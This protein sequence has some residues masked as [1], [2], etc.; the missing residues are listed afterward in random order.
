MLLLSLLVEAVREFHWFCWIRLA[1]I[2]F[3]LIQITMC[4]DYG[5]I[6]SCQAESEYHMQ[7][8]N[9]DVHVLKLEASVPEAVYLGQR[10]DG[11]QPEANE[12]YRVRK[13]WRSL[14]SARFETVLVKITNSDG[15]VGWGEALAPVGPGILAETIRSLI[16]PQLIGRDPRF[17]RPLWSELRGLMR[18]RGH[19]VGHQADALAAVDIALWDLVGHIHGLSVS[20]MIGGAFHQEVPVYISGLPVPTNNERAKLAKDWF[21]K[22]AG[23]VKLHVGFGVQEDLAIFDAVAAAAPG[24]GIA[25]DAHWVYSR[26]DA[27]KLGRELDERGALFLEAPLAPEDVAGHVALQSHLST[28]VAVGE[29]LRNRYEFSQWVNAGAL[30]IL[31]PDIG[32]TG[33]TE[34]M[35]ISDLATTNHLLVAPHHSVGLGISFA[36]GMH[37]AAASESLLLFEYQP[38]TLEMASKILT[39]PMT[40]PPDLVPLPSGPGLGITVDEDFVNAYSIHAS[41]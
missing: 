13:P 10:P 24:L 4:I 29:T 14:Y 34:G 11:T 6:G 26:S 7:I 31:Q 28:P 9:V 2:T 12:G 38:S 40:T 33:I 27:L 1:S 23:A 30:Q 18:E 25:V 22:G 39:E 35:L 36:A 3:E 41:N 32:R 5:Y 37:V 19:L 20:T 16:A 21:E 8:V 15:A 17:I